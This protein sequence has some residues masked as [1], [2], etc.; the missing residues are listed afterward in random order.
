MKRALLL[1]LSALL[2]IACGQSAGK[3]SKARQQEAVTPVAAIENYMAETIG[4]QYRQ[5]EY[6]IPF[7]SVVALDDSNPEDILVWGDFWVENYNL[8]EETL[9]TVSGGS[10]PGLMHLAKT[11]DGYEVKS[12]DAVGD[13]AS[14]TPT[15]KTIFGDFYDAFITL[16][17]DDQVRK[18]AREEA[19]AAFVT[20][21]QIPAKFYQDFGWDAQEIPLK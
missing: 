2:L 4:S 8:E 21:L 1:S 17:S 18:S 9:K 16:Q 11:A 15:A 5:G 13:G 14:F 12:F 19:I 6:C 7:S 20:S 10:H 3:K